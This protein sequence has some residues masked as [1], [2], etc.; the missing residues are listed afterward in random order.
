ML[1]P[2]LE[3]L[4]GPQVRVAVIERDDQSQEHLVAGRVIEESAAF[5]VIIERP[6]ERVHGRAGCMARGIDL[7]DLLEADP[8]V[9]RV[10][11][12]PEVEAAHELLA[13]VA[14]AALRENRVLPAQLV[15][16]LKGRLAAALLVEPHVAG[17]DTRDAAS[18]VVQHVDRRESGKHIRAER[19][20][21]FREPLAKPAQADDVVAVVA[22][23]RR[24]Q[25]RRYAYRRVRRPQIVHLVVMHGGRQRCAARRP[26]GEQFRERPRIEEVARQDVRADLGTLFQDHDRQGIVEL[27]QPTGCR[28]AGGA[29]SDD[30]HVEFHRFSF[31]GSAALVHRSPVVPV[32]RR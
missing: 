13:E 5:R 18:A 17:R 19:F 30:H 22:H 12:G 11:A 23:R 7:P 29:A 27:E 16:R 15:A 25:R 9:L 4:E 8:V 3:F 24:Y 31:A 6:A 26:V 21:L 2:A 20:G 1:F 10:H 32:L 28:Q 14:A